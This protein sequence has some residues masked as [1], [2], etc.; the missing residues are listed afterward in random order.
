MVNCRTAL[1]LVGAFDAG[2]SVELHPAMAHDAGLSV[3]YGRRYYA[4]YPER[5]II[6]VPLT[7]AG[8]LSAARLS[9]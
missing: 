1:R 8:F 6:K 9:S 3:E 4:V 5:F 7:P 2:V